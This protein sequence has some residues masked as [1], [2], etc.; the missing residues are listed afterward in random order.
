MGATVKPID[1]KLGALGNNGGSTPTVALR[2]G[3]PAIG[4]GGSANAPATDQR[5]DPRPHGAIDGGA[6]EYT[7]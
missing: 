4:A 5:G 3:S 2:P 7:T 6:F 1:P